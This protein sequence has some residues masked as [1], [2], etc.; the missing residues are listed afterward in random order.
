MEALTLRSGNPGETK[1]R[2]H[3]AVTGLN[4]LD[5]S[6]PSQGPTWHSSHKGMLK[7]CMQ[8]TAVRKLQKVLVR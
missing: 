4:V 3:G 1:L 8:N 5:L 6:L 7:G 2:L